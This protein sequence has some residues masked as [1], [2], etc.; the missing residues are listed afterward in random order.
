MMLRVM[1]YA[2]MLG[3]PVIAHAEDAGLTGEAVATA[4]EMATRLG[5]PSA[6]AE[7]EALAIARDIALAE[8]AG[9]H[10]HIRQVTTAAGLDLVRA[11]KAR[12][13]RVTCGVT[14]AY[15]ML[16]DLATAGFPH[17]HPPVA[18]AAQRSGPAGGARGAGRRH[19]RR[20]RIRPRPAR[21]GGQAPALRRCGARAW[22]ARK[23]CCR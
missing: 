2:A 15:F 7:A 14:P 5:L 10:L 17:L 1:Q 12:G 6:P 22:R 13:V 16:S 8:M 19:D 11:A 9:A 23:R 21:A 4:G 20:D 18:P 3:L